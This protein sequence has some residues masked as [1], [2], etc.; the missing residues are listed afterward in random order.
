[1]AGE[2]LKGFSF[3]RARGRTGKGDAFRLAGLGEDLRGEKPKR[4]RRSLLRV[5]N[6][7]KGNWL[8]VGRKSLERRIRVEA[9]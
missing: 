7:E 4:A 9:P 3:E 5:N 8:Y 1:L 6:L 2:E